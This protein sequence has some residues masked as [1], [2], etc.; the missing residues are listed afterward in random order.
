MRYL[1][2][3]AVTLSAS[4]G[5]V[6][7]VGSSHEQ[8]AGET[9]G[10]GDG[11]GDDTAD[12]DEVGDGDPQGCGFAQPEPLPGP[13][14]DPLV[15]GA[16]V[17]E[18]PAPPN[19]PPPAACGSG[20]PCPT[21]SDVSEA[22][23]LVYAQY[24]P[25]SSADAECIFDLP[26][27]QGVVFNSN[28]EPQWISGGV[29]VGD[30]DGDGW[31]DLYVTRLAA[32]D[33][34]FHNRGDGTFE[35]VA[36][37]VGLG[38][39]TFTNGAAWADVDDDGDLDL[40]VTALGG[41]AHHLFINEGGCFVDEAEARGFALTVDTKRSGQSVTFGDYDLDGILDAHVNE[42][43]DDAD[44]DDVGVWGSR[45]LHGL[46][47]GVFEDVTEAAGVS[48]ADIV[49][50][51]DGAW[52]FAST[53]VDLDDDGLPDLAI[54]ADFGEARLFWNEGDGSF[55]D[56]TLAAGVADEGNAMG[57][58]FGDYDGDGRLDWFVGAIAEQS[59][60]GCPIDECVWRGTGNRLYRNR[61]DRSFEDV[62]EAAG[63]RD[64][65]WAWGSA[66]FDADHDG[67]LD[68][69]QTNG[70]PGRGGYGTFAHLDTPM[71]LWLN[72]GGV[73]DELGA[74]RGIQDTGQGRGLVTFDY[75]RDGDLDVFVANHRGRPVLYRNDGAEQV[76]WLVVEV[77]GSG[78]NRDG[79]GAVVEV[80]AV[81]DGPAQ[82]R[83]IGVGAHFLGETE[84]GAHFGLGEGTTSVHEVRVRWPASGEQVVLGE[85]APGQRLHVIEP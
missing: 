58:T 21:F 50:L 10:D 37:E 30:Y 77:E 84:L 31:P 40:A 7:S 33:L 63:V 52:G 28:C 18:A 19:P 23:G 26:S 48:I 32:P 57:T 83:Q 71:R 46:G 43:I 4:A 47:D 65:G 66:L 29:A 9:A 13:P 59:P 20:G 36:A 72:E 81:A 34:L 17:P 51:R 80:Q 44:R 16:W 2:L 53:F 56:G 73:F 6:V 79:R 49:F 25:T 3:V 42:W 54:A 60:E 61:G 62:T 15:C 74:E 68:I 69:V 55:S 22:A 8:G 76:P 1:A 5:C 38:D 24:I 14:F 75:D 41:R 11:D 35:D 45:L 27:G 64:G 82:I 70:W 67:D 39:C 78:S 85:V 12:G